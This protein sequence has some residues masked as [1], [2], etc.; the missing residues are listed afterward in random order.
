MQEGIQ[1]FGLELRIRRL[2]PLIEEQRN[3]PPAGFCHRNHKV[4]GLIVLKH[5]QQNAAC[6]EGLI[7]GDQGINHGSPADRPA[8]RIWPRAVMSN[9]QRSRRR[10]MTGN[11]TTRRATRPKW[12]LFSLGQREYAEPK[13][14]LGIGYGKG[15]PILFATLRVGT[16]LGARWKVREFD[17]APGGNV[18]NLLPRGIAKIIEFF[19][20]DIYAEIVRVYYPH[21]A[22][23]LFGGRRRR[24]Q[25]EDHPHGYQCKRPCE[26]TRRDSHG[27]YNLSNGIG[28]ASPEPDSEPPGGA[29]GRE[30]RCAVSS[31]GDR[32]LGAS[33]SVCT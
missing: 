16:E 22:R 23:Y 9:R 25:G 15:A 19:R 28:L 30:P 6:G 1:G 7:G 26:R 21:H 4:T 11:E 32:I 10:S 20:I 14:T 29:T 2:L 8:L 17:T 27:H 31:S 3:R 5:W 18:A 24:R 12:A 33:A 13:S